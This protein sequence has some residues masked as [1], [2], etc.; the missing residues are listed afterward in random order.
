MPGGWLEGREAG[1]VGQ[2]R[3]R[4]AG[5]PR[6]P[7][8]RVADWQRDHRALPRRHLRHVHGQGSAA[9][10]RAADLRRVRRHFPGQVPGRPMSADAGQCRHR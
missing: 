3:S 9:G 1:V 5:G 2:P 10:E 7:G 8:E 6:D 4:A